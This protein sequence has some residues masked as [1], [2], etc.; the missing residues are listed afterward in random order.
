MPNSTH[1]NDLN[2][3]SRFFKLP[4]PN[5]LE[6]DD[7]I[8]DVFENAVFACGRNA[9]VS[10]RCYNR[11]NASLLED[12]SE[13]CQSSPPFRFIEERFEHTYG[14]QN[15]PLN[16]RVINH[17][18]QIAFYLPQ[19]LLNFDRFKF[20][21][22]QVFPQVISEV[23]AETLRIL[24]NTLFILIEAYIH[25]VFTILQTSVDELKC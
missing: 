21:Y 25:T 2:T 3:Q 22:L 5:E 23:H 7:S 14:V 10:F 20:N 11:G 4:P 19:R 8:R 13:S 9:L 18:R 6:T 1:L 17:R 16:V 24:Q 15:Y 12:V